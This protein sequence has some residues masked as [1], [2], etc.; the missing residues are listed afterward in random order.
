MKCQAQKKYILSYSIYMKF[1]LHNQSRVIEVRIV[2]TLEGV[3]TWM[4]HE[5]AFRSAGSVLCL[6]W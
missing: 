6:E 3:L 5:G 2:D 1:Y 4:K